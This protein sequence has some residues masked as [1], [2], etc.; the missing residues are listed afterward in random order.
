MP[1]VS[2]RTREDR[3]ALLEPLLARRIL[4]LDGAMGTMIQTYHLGER[5]YRGDRF[6]DWPRDLRGHSDLL[7]LTQPEV[8]RAIHS[9]YLEAGADIIETNSFTST[10]VSLADYGMA[11][12]VYEFN[13]AAARL[14]REAA[15]EFEASGS[16][17]AA[18]RRRRARPDQSHAPRMSPDVNDPGARYTGFDELAATY[19][20]AAQALL[21]GGADL[22]L[23]ETIFDTLNAK[24]AI[25]AVDA[26]FESLGWRVPLMISGTI[27]DAARPDPVGPD[28][29]GVLELGGA[30]SPAQCRAQLR[31]RRR[32]A[33][34][35][36]AGALADRARAGEHAPERRAA[37]RVRRLRRDA[38]VHGG[39]AGGVRGAGTAESRGWVLRHHARAHPRHR[40][41]RARPPAPCAAHPAVALPSQRSRAPHDRSRD[42]LRERGRADQRDRLAQVRPADSRQR[43]RCRPRDRT[44]AGRDRRADDRRQH[45][46]GAARLGA[47]D[48]HVPQPRRLRAWHQQG[49]AGDRLVQVVGHRSGPQVR[50][51]ERR[52]Q[53]HQPQGGRGGVRSPGHAGA[54]LRCRGDRDGLRREGPGRHGRAEGGDLSAELPHSHRAGGVRSFG[55]HF[56]SEH[57]RHRHRD[58]GARQ[59]RAGLHRGDPAASRRSCPACS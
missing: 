20:E 46:R 2:L 25:F 19:R 54:S 42:A 52:R 26:L 51:G 23:I 57:L 17:H 56:R 14:A 33:P 18:L 4:V 59:L 35:L 58:R 40:R 48:D 7:T 22:L 8:I 49:A 47:G 37:Q 45:G 50:P 1:N 55:H 9:A 39:C 24:A 21:D 13:F 43:V 44:P 12:M 41:R 15:D 38:R 36:R 6:A 5:D 11:D 28:H 34:S 32:H 3:I 29:R 53:L 31:P 30:C 16:R 27:T 10:S